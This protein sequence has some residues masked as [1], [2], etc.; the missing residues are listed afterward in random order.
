MWSQLNVLT[1]NAHI[2]EFVVS[3]VSAQNTELHIG[4]ILMLSSAYKVFNTIFHFLLNYSH[5]CL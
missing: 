5:K 2:S 1:Q 3:S 4:P